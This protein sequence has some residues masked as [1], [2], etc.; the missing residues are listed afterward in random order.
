M[1]TVT[2][3]I[4]A[5]RTTEAHDIRQ[6]FGELIADPR[7]PDAYSDFFAKRLCKAGSKMCARRWLFPIAGPS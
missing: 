1:A 6:L 7:T 2:V 5:Q 3:S 4:T